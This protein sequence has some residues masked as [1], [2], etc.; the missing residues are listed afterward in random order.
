MFEKLINLKIPI[1]ELFKNSF[2]AVVSY[3]I[4]TTKATLNEVLLERKDLQ[5]TLNEVLLERKDLQATLNTIREELKIAKAERDQAA[6]TLKQI[7]ES[8]TEQ[9]VNPANV[10]LILAQND[11]TKFVVI[12]VLI[13]G[14]VVLV[15]YT[16]PFSLKF[17]LKS[18]LPVSCVEFLQKHTPLCQ[19]RESITWRD[20]KNDLDWV[21]SII[22][23]KTYEAFVKPSGFTDFQSAG[24]LITK[25][26]ASAGTLVQSPALQKSSTEFSLLT[27]ADSKDAIPQASAAV[28]KGLERLGN[29]F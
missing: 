3:Q 21:L 22:N 17:S 16:S 4:Y 18:L 29:A 13:V 6:N 28:L 15:Y 25:L 24:N 20:D 10:E 14:A 23:G 9:T 26:N 27:L 5:A 11:M 7:T 2:Y 12:T 1:G 8:F 19:T